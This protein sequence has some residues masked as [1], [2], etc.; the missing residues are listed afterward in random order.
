MKSWSYQQITE[1]AEESIQRSM[2]LAKEAAVKG[3]DGGCHIFHCFAKGA[4]FAWSD[5]TMGWQTD[6][7]GKRLEALTHPEWALTSATTKRT[8]QPTGNP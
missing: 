4:Y 2:G 5:L 7:A 6:D 3:D 8:D 1:K